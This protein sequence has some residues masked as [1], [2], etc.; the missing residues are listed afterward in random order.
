M[1]LCGEAF[2][3]NSKQLYSIQNQ[4]KLKLEG[5]QEVM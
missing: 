1:P 3:N 4:N 5:L 2:K